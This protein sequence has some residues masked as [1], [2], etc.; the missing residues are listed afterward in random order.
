[1]I[2]ALIHCNMKFKEWLDKGEGGQW[3][4]PYVTNRDLLFVGIITAIGCS[5]IITAG[6]V[7]SKFY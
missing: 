1:M 2:N 6:W 4:E 7:I 3:Y 5:I